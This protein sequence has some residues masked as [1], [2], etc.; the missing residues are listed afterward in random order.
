MNENEQVYH[1]P[2]WVGR[3]TRETILAKNSVE[4]WQTFVLVTNNRPKEY[5]GGW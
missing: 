4:L 5:N 1:H 2:N 3:L